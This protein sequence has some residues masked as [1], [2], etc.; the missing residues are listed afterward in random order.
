[1][2]REK[3]ARSKEE[4]RAVLRSLNIPEFDP[5]ESNANLMNQVFIFEYSERGKIK[6][7]ICYRPKWHYQNGLFEIFLN[8]AQHANKDFRF[9]DESSFKSAFTQAKAWAER[10]LDKL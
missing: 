5:D 4:A 3:K 6:L 9:T 2:V 7:E 1:M 10:Q 8:D